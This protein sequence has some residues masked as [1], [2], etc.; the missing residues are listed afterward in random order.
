MT[1]LARNVGGHTDAVR[2]DFARSGS[3][4]PGAALE[5]LG[6]RRR[7]AITA[8]AATGVPNRRVEAWKYTD[9]ANLLEPDLLPITGRQE[10]NGTPTGEPVLGETNRLQLSGGFISRFTVDDSIDVIDLSAL[11][12]EVPGWVREN[13]GTLACGPE[14]P[15]GAASLALMRGGAAIR[16]RRDTSVGLHFFNGVLM[17][18]SVSH[19]RILVL[20]E[21]GV[22]V[23]LIESHT[24]E[25]ASGSLRNIGME[26]VLGPNSRLEH[27]RLQKDAADAFHV[28]SIGAML[29][30]DSQYRACFAALGAGVSRLDVNIRLAERNGEAV[31]HH[32]AA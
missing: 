6:D 23:R 2:D 19:C 18:P 25:T 27:I 17:R 22:S 28:T 30:R 31:L 14:Q 13:L 32:V 16:I 3:E 21:S 11:R 9:L 15:L 1:A 10:D 29:G 8:F 20:V 24:G 5:W 12:G 26:L 4:L 7:A